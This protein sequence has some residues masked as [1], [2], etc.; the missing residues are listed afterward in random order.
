MPDR[1]ENVFTVVTLLSALLGGL[2]AAAWAVWFCAV[3]YPDGYAINGLVIFLAPACFIAGLWI[4]GF[5][6]Q[7][8]YNWIISE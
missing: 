2:G 4:T 1:A 6:T 8:V 3:R 5:I 7:A